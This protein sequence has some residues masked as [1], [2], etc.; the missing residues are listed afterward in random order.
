MRVTLSTTASFFLWV[1]PR[2]EYGYAYFS[3]DKKGGSGW[4]VDR[5]GHA[6][7]GSQGYQSAEDKQHQQR[8]WRQRLQNDQECRP[9]TY[10]ARWASFGSTSPDGGTTFMCVAAIAC[11]GTP[12]CANGQMTPCSACDRVGP[13]L[14]VQIHDTLAALAGMFLL[15][16]FISH[17]G[18]SLAM[19]FSVSSSI[20]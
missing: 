19:V 3:R 13:L 18:Q 15:E 8:R 9:G 17:L 6:R 2:L 1:S 14:F 11:C 20:S 5:R 7:I 16:P 12:A 4:P 10:N